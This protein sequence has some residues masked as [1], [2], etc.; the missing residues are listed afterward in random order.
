MERRLLQPFAYS[1]STNFVSADFTVTDPIAKAIADR[2]DLTSYGI[3]AMVTG[4]GNCLFNAVS[5][6]LCGNEVLSTE[7]R[8][9]SA[10]EMLC[11]PDRNRSRPDYKNLLMVSPSFEE[12]C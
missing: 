1:N 4:D 8:L 7:I 9:R 11:N 12:A 5:I 6:A 2:C 10:I 3:P